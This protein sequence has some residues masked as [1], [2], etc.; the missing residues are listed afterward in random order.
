MHILTWNCNGALRKKL[1]ALAR[2]D[3]D[4]AVIQECEDPD[5][6]TSTLYKSWAKN[7]LWS[8]TNK[9]KG[10]GVFAAPGTSLVPVDLDQG[11]LEL[12]LPCRIND[13]FLLVASWTRQANSPTFQYIGQLWKFIQAH[14]TA[15]SAQPTVIAGDLNSNARWDKW[16]RWWNHTDVVRAL[17]EMG[18]ESAYHLSHR[19]PQGSEPE[20]TFYLQRNL[21]KAYHIDYVF[22]PA[23]WL[24]AGSAWVGDAETW[25]Q[26]SDH[27]PLIVRLN[28]SDA[29]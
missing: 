20:P 24:G 14:R 19:I 15:L 8:G 5:R 13:S 3:F 1:D 17:S 7:Y 27:M 25:L 11:Q 12:F 23:E 10:V 2:L 9:N 21:A 6:S 29:P 22:A 16:D 4:V 26:W 28:P 18:M